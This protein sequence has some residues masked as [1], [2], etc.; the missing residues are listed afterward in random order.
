MV[1]TSVMPRGGSRRRKSME[2]R[3]LMNENGSL[4]AARGKG[5]QRRSVSAETFTEKMRE[6]LVNTP[7]RGLVLEKASEQGQNDK[8]ISQRDDG[9]D[10]NQDDDNDDT[11]EIH[12]PAQ[13]PTGYVKYDP[14]TDMSPATPYL[15]NQANRLA[16]MSCPPKQ[17]GQG[18][19]DDNNH[20]GPMQRDP[21]DVEDEGMRRRL[22]AVR[23]KTMAGWKPKIG[24][25]LGRE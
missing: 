5:G 3:A 4:S 16:Q 7:V 19:F 1:D 23:R 15:L 24:S 12:L 10:E 13:T 17:T 18:L 2:P 14:T 20:N 6:E 9:A 21:G 25:P 11:T 8:G 22:E